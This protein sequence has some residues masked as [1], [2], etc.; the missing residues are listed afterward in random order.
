MTKRD[1]RQRDALDMR[2]RA[3]ALAREAA[4]GETEAPAGLSPK[5]IQEMLHELR[6]HQIQLELQNEDLRRAQEAIGAARARYF[7]LYDLAP[8]GYCTL[9]ETGMILEANL[10]LAT[11]LGLDRGALN[12]QP[13]S[14]FVLE[15]DQGIYYLHRKQLFDTGEPQ[16]CELRLVRPDG[17]PFWAHL[18][19]TAARA[20]DG[21]P[22][23]RVIISDITERK[24]VEE[25]LRDSEQKFQTLVNQAP[26]ALFL[27]GIDGF[28]V[29]Y[30]QFTLDK[31]G[32]SADEILNIKA[33]DID[34]DYR[35]RENMGLFW[36]ELKRKGQLRFE[37]RHRNKGGAI[38]PVEVNLAPIEI[39]GKKHYLAMALDITERKQAEEA[40]A[41]SD[42]LMRFVIEHSNSGVAIHDRSLNYLYVSQRYLDMYHVQKQ[43]VLGRH[44][45][46]VFPDLPQ[47][48][49]EV[50]QKALAGEVSSSDRD[51][52]MRADGT[53]EY[54]RWECRPWYEA[55]GSVGGIIVYTEVITDQL[56][57][58][59][60]LREYA[61]KLSES[62]E[63]LRITLNSIGDA[64]IS[65]DVDGRVVSMNPVAEALTG[66]STAEPRGRPLDE[67]FRIVNELTR[68]T[69][70]SPVARVLREGKIVGLANHTLLIDRQG[71]ER[72][73]ADSGAP[74][75]DGQGQIAGVVLVFRDQTEEKR[76]ET[77]L[78]AEREN[79]RAIVDG[80]PA[81]VF[82]VDEAE[83]V[84]SANPETERL[85]GVTGHELD[86]KRRFG[87]LAGCVHCHDDPRGCGFGPSCS[88][89]EVNGAL[90]QALGGH[91][92][93]NREVSLEVQH[94]GGSATRV[95]VLGAAPVTTRTG[96]GAALA[97]QDI[98]ALR[99]ALAE[100]ERLQASL[101]QSDRLASM[102]M[103]AAGVAHEINNPLSYVLY[104]VES[105]AEDLP[106][107]A[108]D[109]RRCHDA[110]FRHLGPEEAA[111][112]LGERPD[113]GLPAA[114]EDVVVRLR[115]AA[116]GANRIKEIARG[117][118]TFSRVDR[119]EV[120]PVQ[121]Q[122]VIEQALNMAFNQIKYRAQ[123]VRDY[124]PIPPV[125]AA[126]GKLAQVFLNLFINAAHAI[127]EGH[128]EE[129]KIRVRAWAEGEA[130]LAEV[131]DTGKGIAPEHHDRIF[132]PFFTT[133]EVGVGSG[134]GLAIARN[135]VTGFGGEIS[136]SSEP[137]KGT[138]F[139]I[140]LPRLPRDWQTREASPT[141]DAPTRSTTRG[142]ILVVDDEPG[143]RAIIAR[144]LGRDH[145]VVTAASG[146]EARAILEQDRR[147]DL[148]FCDMMMPRISGM[149]LHAWLAARDA[150][151][152]LAARVVFITGGAFTPGA[153]DYLARVG[154]L[155]VEK[156]FDTV[157]LKKLT[158]ELILA[159]RA[160]RN[161]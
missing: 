32:Y 2:Q 64:V 98:T 138:R 6:V 90:K 46:E 38:F 108:D 133:K 112:A 40:L 1:D 69:V 99:E 53:V 155:R 102:G 14:R 55:D 33:S 10:T 12:K 25:A 28:I 118:G 66:W 153:S 36:E 22:L 149:E 157:A 4:A 93:R 111:R 58:E 106:R 92:I 145:E 67:V 95:F 89:C 8:V 110:L 84:V 52:F 116:S 47:K 42:Q 105:A 65:T 37:G 70:E 103:L 54:T 91:A 20:E 16:E 141:E 18:K 68:A 44:H 39:K 11:L 127:D 140:R 73:I 34:P 128:V 59:Q 5:E 29:E 119:D 80:T 160:R 9:S 60:S 126:D 97:L 139:L 23:C 76:Q 158:D 87:D 61:E 56:R 101:A 3:E 63:N 123:V 83:V 77:A 35:E 27:H 146:E 107:L 142:R 41:H 7:D 137:G 115:E 88:S 50:H 45:Y 49:R 57:Q 17:A 129:N 132:Q 124:D 100:R 96:R 85:F 134:L 75:R 131:S 51:P 135:I 117:L 109:V 113:T 71:G 114:M 147:F 104:N 161:N 24:E 125:L 122:P 81:A 30:N 19:G 154:N 43:Q 152:D 148:I 156:P 78:I 150:D 82:I 130:V 79:L 74:I 159:A 136:F 62:E 72:P 143:I 94:N 120:M 121:L 26:A 48:W 15:E 13:V 86:G 151:R 144:I 21:A 31:Y